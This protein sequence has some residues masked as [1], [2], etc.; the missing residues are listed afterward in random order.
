M[1]P[2]F[3]Y[4]NRLKYYRCWGAKNKKKTEIDHLFTMLSCRTRPGAYE[5]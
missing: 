2:T 1:Y 5:T 4:A 3:L